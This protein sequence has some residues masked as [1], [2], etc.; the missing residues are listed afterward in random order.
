MVAQTVGTEP[1]PPEKYAPLRVFENGGTTS[2][3]SVARPAESGFR[4]L[5]AGRGEAGGC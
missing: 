1:D 2:V 3:S 4:L 5:V